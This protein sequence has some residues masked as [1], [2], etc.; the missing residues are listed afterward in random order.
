MVTRHF[1]PEP[2]S[3]ERRSLPVM[4][5]LGFQHKNG[6]L[7]QVKTSREMH[8]LLARGTGEDTD[9]STVCPIHSALA[10]LH[11]QRTLPQFRR[12]EITVPCIQDGFNEDRT[13][14]ARYRPAMDAILHVIEE[15]RPGLLQVI[16]SAPCINSN[17]CDRQLWRRT[18]RHR[19]EGTIA[20]QP[21][22]RV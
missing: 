5:Q 17:S 6:M 18:S 21:F 14:T 15:V 16:P 2:I 10:M 9:D 4:E 12:K 22:R 11:L 13:H 3:N 19:R 7:L 8:A 1:P 20:I